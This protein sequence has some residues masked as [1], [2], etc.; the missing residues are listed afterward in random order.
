MPAV[1]FMPG[2]Q[3]DPAIPKDWARRGY[4]AVTAAPRGKLRSNGQFNPGYP[5]LLTHNIIDRNTY[6]YRGF[7]VDAWRTIDYLLTR[8]EVDSERIGVAGRQPG[9][10]SDDNDCGDASGGEGSVGG[11]AVSLRLHGCDRADQ[12]LPIPGDQRLPAD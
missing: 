4:A 9:W 6:S 11:G 12:Q 3:S 10:R 2:Y 7:Y 8:D 5:N 1:V